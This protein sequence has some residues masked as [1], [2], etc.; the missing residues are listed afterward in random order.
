MPRCIDEIQF[1]DL[2][3]CGSVVER[4]TLRLDGNSPF[5]LQVHGIENLV[6]HF[7]LTESAA[8]LNKAIRQRGLAVIHV[9]DYRKVSD[10]LLF[11]ARDKLRL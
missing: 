1:V 9:R 2:T 7:T 3:I 5:T 6:R 8:Q 4:Y 11:H 10:A